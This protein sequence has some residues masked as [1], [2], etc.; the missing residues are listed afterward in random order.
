MLGVFMLNVVIL[1]VVAPC[2][3]GALFLLI[4]DNCCSE[5]VFAQAKTH[6]MFVAIAT[7]FDLK[8]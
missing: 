7:Y 4:V 8:R 2:K 1:S 6:S 3:F 5:V